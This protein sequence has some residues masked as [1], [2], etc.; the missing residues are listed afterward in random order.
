MGALSDQGGGGSVGNC[1]RRGERPLSS[2]HSLK[3]ID[4]GLNRLHPRIAPI[5]VSDLSGKA[6]RYPRLGGDGRPTIRACFPKPTPEVV[7]D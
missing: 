4:Q 5:G 7:D 3:Q 1:T 2:V 6:F